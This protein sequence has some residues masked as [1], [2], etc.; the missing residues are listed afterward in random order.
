MH[1]IRMRTVRCSGRLVGGWIGGG[2]C[3][4]ECLPGGGVSAWRGCVYLE[5]VC[6][7]GG[8]VSAWKECLPG[9]GVSAR[10]VPAWG[11]LPRRGGVCLGG[12]HLP[13]L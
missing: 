1:S 9:G 4:G 8:G 10:G 5:G 2:V 6:L 11:C 13:S 3:L 12:V 7:P